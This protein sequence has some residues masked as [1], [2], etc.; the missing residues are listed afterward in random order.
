MLKNLWNDFFEPYCSR[1]FYLLKRNMF[2]DK[3]TP[4]LATVY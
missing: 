1:T 3:E 2:C 4:T